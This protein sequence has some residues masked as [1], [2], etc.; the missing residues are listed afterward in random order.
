MN[1]KYAK[2]LDEAIKQFSKEEH[3]EVVF[4]REQL[5]DHVSFNF[6]TE[7]GTWENIMFW[8]GVNYEE[9]RNKAEN[10]N[11]ESKP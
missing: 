6:A 8:I 4:E 2:Y 5:G 11:S 7:G 3:I 9:I 10:T 1:V